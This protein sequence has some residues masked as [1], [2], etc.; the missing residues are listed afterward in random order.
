MKPSGMPKAWREICGELGR[1]RKELSKRL[2]T[3]VGNDG[4]LGVHMTWT[5]SGLTIERTIDGRVDG[6]PLTFS[7]ADH[8]TRY[9][10]LSL[11]FIS[12]FDGVL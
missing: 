4:E 11:M 2:I 3:H 7:N 6:E 9:L 1:D 8:T 10:I 5:S 12:C